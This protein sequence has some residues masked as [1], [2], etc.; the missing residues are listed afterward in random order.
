MPNQQRRFRGVFDK[1]ATITRRNP[2]T[3]TIDTVVADLSV[4][5]LGPIQARGL[6]PSLQ[7]SELNT[8]RSVKQCFHIP[9]KGV[10]LP[11]IEDGDR[12]THDG[13]EYAVIFAGTW[14]LPW[15][16]LH[17]VVDKIWGT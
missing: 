14:D 2:A 12:I 3:G 11:D 16:A 1:L 9:A 7:R 8:P 15:D 4:T 17:I 5:P 6:P 13:T 10:P